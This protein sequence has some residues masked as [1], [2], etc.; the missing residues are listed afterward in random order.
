MVPEEAD[1]REGAPEYTGRLCVIGSDL[2]EDKLK[3]LFK[4]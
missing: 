1:V 4:L 3:E 2:K